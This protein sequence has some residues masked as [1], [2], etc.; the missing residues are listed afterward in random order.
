MKPL[1][2]FAGSAE[3]DAFADADERALLEGF[4]GASVS[5]D[6]LVDAGVFD[7]FDDVF[8]EDDMAGAP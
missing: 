2:Q 4:E 8:D 7:A 6:K 5:G 1:P 3:E